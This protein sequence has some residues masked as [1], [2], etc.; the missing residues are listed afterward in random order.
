LRKQACCLWDEEKGFSVSSHD[1]NNTSGILCLH[2]YEDI[3]RFNYEHCF[4]VLNQHPLCGNRH[5]HDSE[6]GDGVLSVL[7]P[8]APVGRQTLKINMLSPFQR[9]NGDAFFT[10]LRPRRRRQ[11]VSL[12]R[13]ECTYE[14]TRRHSPE[15]QHCRY[16]LNK[17]QGNAAATHSY[18]KFRGVL[19][20]T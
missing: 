14:C 12:Q 6:D 20:L 4:S 15:L 10:S 18:S 1:S 5:S 3:S 11:H 7:T 16:P 9:R 2:L 8:C 17:L 19:R 13:S